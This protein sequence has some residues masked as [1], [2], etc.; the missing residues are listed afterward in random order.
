MNIDVKILPFIIQ[1]Y[2]EIIIC[3]D[4]FRLYQGCSLPL[5]CGMCIIHLTNTVKEKERLHGPLKRHTH[6]HTNH[7]TKLETHP[8][9]NL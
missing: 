5:E 1:G 8:Q 4:E 7:L 6:T 2:P 3:Q 9:E